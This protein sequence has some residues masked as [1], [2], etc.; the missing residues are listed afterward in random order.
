MKAW[1]NTTRQSQN[2]QRRT[3]LENKLQ[4][5]IISDPKQPRRPVQEILN[6]PRPG[7][8][9]RHQI[10]KFQKNT[11]QRLEHVGKYSTDGAQKSSMEKQWK[12]IFKI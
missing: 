5:K 1:R 8:V 11:R 6:P 12:N 2:I 7:T 3:R 9:L 4:V 10:K